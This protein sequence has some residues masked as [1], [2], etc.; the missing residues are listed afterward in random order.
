MNALEL[1]NL[2]RSRAEKYSKTSKESLVRNNHLNEIKDQ[3]DLEQRVIDA[4]LVDFVNYCAGCAGI[5]YALQTS[6]LRKKETTT[7]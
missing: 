5:D 7:K 6:D 1:S 2:V 3:E 4:V